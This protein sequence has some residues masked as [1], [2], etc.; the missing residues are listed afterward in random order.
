MKKQ[1]TVLAILI[2]STLGLKAQQ[3]EI[4]FTDFEPD[5]VITNTEEEAIVI[6]FDNDGTNDIRFNMTWHSAGGYMTH[7]KVSGNWRMSEVPDDNDTLTSIELWGYGYDW[8]EY[9]ESE[10]FAARKPVD[11]GFVYVWFRAYWYRTINPSTYHIV[12]DKFAYCTIPDYPLLWG[13]TTITAGVEEE[14]IENDF[15][16]YPNPANGFLFV[17][18]HGGAS[19]PD[20]TYHITNLMGQTLLQGQITA[21]T[22]Q[23]NIENLPAGMYSITFAN[24]TRKFVVR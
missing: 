15:V 21:E 8:Y 13:Q 12:F 22:Q 7:I 1:L 20:P 14:T 2:M 24:D 16:I 3:S 17:E 4:I 6:D 11:N 19:L 9:G 10:R 18:T 23:I 5:L